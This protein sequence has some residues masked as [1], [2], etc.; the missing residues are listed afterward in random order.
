VTDFTNVASYVKICGV[1]SVEDA[2]VVIEAG[3]DALGLI[4]AESTR[5]LSPRDG[6]RIAEAT[7]GAIIRVGVFRH[8]SD[9][10]V[11]ESVDESG[12]DVAQLHGPLSEGL[13]DGLRRRGVGIIKAFSV[14]SDDFQRF[15]EV[16]VDAVLV[17]GPT[18]GSGRE[19]SWPDFKVRDFQRPLIIAGG[20][21]PEN[22]AALA[23]GTAAW[24]VDVSTGV[25]TAPG[26]KDAARVRD[27]VANARA[28]L[29]TRGTT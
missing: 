18:P 29:A 10:F 19:H 21:Q 12:V 16:L 11:L 8:D 25:E 5:Q 4:F 6:R 3:A 9:Q 23:R 1:T 20:L 22:V 27:F 28:A 14:Q 2:Q 7:R 13:L 15:D 17:D 26:M 24:G